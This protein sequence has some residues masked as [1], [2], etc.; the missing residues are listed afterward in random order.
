MEIKALDQA[1]R[2]DVHRVADEVR[3]EMARQR[4]TAGDLANVIGVTQ[5]T[6][7]RRLNGT[8]PF[9]VYELSQV[10]M[11]LGVTAADLIA[12]GIGERVAS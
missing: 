5:H 11:W 7:G 1:A 9:D 8:I 3:A 4:K 6:A 2:A 12:R 10:A